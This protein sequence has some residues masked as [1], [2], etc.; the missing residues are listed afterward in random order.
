MESHNTHFL[1]SG[2]LVLF[3]VF[4]FRFNHILRVSDIHSFLFLCSTP[5]YKYITICFSDLIDIWVIS[6]LGKLW[7]ELP[8][9][10]MYNPFVDICCHVFCINSEDWD[11][12]IKGQVCIYLCK[13][14]P[15]QFFQNGSAIYIPTTVYKNFSSVLSL[16]F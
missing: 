11:F 9:M 15:Y 14:L 16:S 6:S 2:F 13:N 10:L 3:F 12:V 1:V 7:M 4:V 5:L 8:W